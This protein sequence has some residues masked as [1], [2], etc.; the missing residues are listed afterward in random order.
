MHQNIIGKNVRITKNVREH[1]ANKMQN[2]KVHS[3]KIIDANIICEHI[4]EEYIVQ[5]TI[6]FGKQVFHD[7]EKE[8]DLY[9]AI[10]TMFQKIERKVRKSKEKNIDKTQRAVVD[11]TVQ[12][13]EDDASYSINTLSL[14]EKPLDEIDALV[15]FN[16]D[17]RPYL[18]YFPIKREEDL[19][20]VKIGK[21]P[22][23]LFKGNDS[24]TYEIYESDDSNSWN[25]DEVSLTSDNNIDASSSKK[26]EL[27]E[28]NVSEAVNYLTENN[29]E[30]FVVYISSVTGQVEAL[31]KESDISFTLIRIFEI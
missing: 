20:S 31:Y 4:H 26:Y 23:Y 10:D 25:I 11:K 5:G 2:I 12:A 7:K 30:K 3:D 27:K 21:Y 18:A 13:D 22:S 19:Y 28:Y 1:I 16:H 8:K 17:K 6:T 24:K 29:N 14:Y 9:V 15:I